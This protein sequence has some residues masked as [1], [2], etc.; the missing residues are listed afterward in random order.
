MKNSSGVTVIAEAG[1]NHNGNMD[2]ARKL[3]DA[4]VVAGADYV[5]F[6]AFSADRLVSKEA[7][8]A[9]YQMDNMDSG[10]NRQY[11][12][13]KKLEIDEGFHEDLKNYAE[14]RAIGFLSSPFDE[15]G[16]DML[17][18]L[19]LRILKV[20][21]GEITNRPYLEKLAGLDCEIILSTGMATLDE[22]K[23]T[24]QILESKDLSREDITV[25][26]CNTDYPTRFKD[27]NL[28]AMTTIKDKLG[29]SIGYSDHSV[30]IEVP[31]AATALG[32]SVIEK[33]YTLDRTME[34]PDHKA[35]LEPGE[36]R[37]MVSAIRNVEQALGN[38]KKVPSESELKN[39]DIV[40]KSI[41][42]LQAMDAGETLQKEDLIMLRPGDGISPMQI[43]QVIGRKLKKKLPQGYKLQYTDLNNES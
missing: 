15:V 41:H 8:K 23:E 10:D 43:N 35:S 34:G 17:Y 7:R 40:R 39:R 9:G 18:K 21:S 6:Q 2:T 32:A 1:V 16:I 13:L 25:L 29:V 31:I 20:P 22:I 19:G 28:R 24:L 12:M 5:K 30:G 42:L 33:H 26:H 38:S 36:L 14:E 27:V 37:D 11:E 4:A 3:V